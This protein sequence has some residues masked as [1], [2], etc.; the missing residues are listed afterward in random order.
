M[1]SKYSSDLSAVY[2]GGGIREKTSSMPGDIVDLFK[3]PSQTYV[4]IRLIG[5]VMQTGSYWVTTRKKDGSTGQFNTGCNSWN[6][7]MHTQD[8]DKPDP[9]RDFER[10][11]I[12]AGVARNDRLVRFSTQYFMNAIIRN[13]QDTEPTRKA[14]HTSN[15]MDSGFKEKDSDSWTPVRVVSLSASVLDAI[16]KMKEINVVKLRKKDGTTV[17][18]KFDV[19]HPKYGCDVLIMYDPTKAGAAKYTVQKGD[20]RTPLTEEEQAYLTYDLD[21]LYETF[22][23]KVMEQSF[24]SW[25]NR[26]DSLIKASFAKGDNEGYV[27]STVSLKS[28]DEEF[29][30]E[31][32]P[33]KKA[34]KQVEEVEDTEGFD[35][36]DFEEEKPVKKTSKKARV[37]DDFEEEPKKPTKKSKSVVEDAEDDFDDDDFEEEKPVKKSASKKPTKKTKELEDDFDDSDFEDEEETPKKSSKK[38]AKRASVEEDDFDD[39]DFEEEKPV[40]KSKKIKEIN[41][42]DDFDSDFDDEDF[43]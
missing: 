25:A 42:D 2:T 8:E 36:A 40:K 35:D 19:T 29:E 34:A 28:R 30:S 6:P 3:L 43:E 22:D 18:K 21:L 38:P 7:E 24:K 33:K 20:G 4:R 39:D 5:G 13:L 14:E 12:E 11:Q 32:R 41:D 31:Y 26:N 16:Q 17:T 1:P 10:D 27:P 23:P 15:E 9:W 37:E